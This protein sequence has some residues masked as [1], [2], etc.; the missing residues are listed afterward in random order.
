MAAEVPTYRYRVDA[1]D[2]L[3]WVD[4]LWLSFAQENGA[5]EL[6]EEAPPGFQLNKM[7]RDDR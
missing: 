6:V 4:S 1:A 3:V 7:R 2:V 5:P